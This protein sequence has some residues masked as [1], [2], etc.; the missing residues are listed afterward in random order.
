[1]L[2]RLRRWLRP[3]PP[4]TAD[5]PFTELDARRLGAIRRYFVRHPVAMDV[6]VALWYSFF[7]VGSSLLVIVGATDA[8]AG[9][10]PYVGGVQL[11]V[12]VLGGLVLMRRRHEPV[13]TVA[14]LVVLAIGCLVLVHEAGGLEFAL[15]LAM[16]A[17]A[18][19]RPPAVTWIVELIMVVVVGAANI[20]W[21][22]SVS[23]EPIR[24][25]EQVVTIVIA[26]IAVLI[27]FSVV[28]IAIGVGVRGRRQHI[29]SL[30]QRANSL[31][32]DREQQA[33]L[34]VADERTRIA[35][36]LHDVVAHSLTVMVALADGARAAVPK[37]PQDAQRALD[38]LT[39]TGRS[40]LSDM[41]RVLGVLR[42]PGDDAPLEP[43][44]D[45]GLDEL[46]ERFRTAG[47][48]VRLVRS[49]ALD[50]LPMAV[51]RST[52]RIVQESL[53]N[54]LRHAPGSPLVLVELE[55]LAD[56]AGERIEI[57]VTNES[58]PVVGGTA[59]VGTGRGILGMRERAASLGG[60]VEAGA[61]ER[62]WQV[63]AVL[64]IGPADAKGGAGA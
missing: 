36:E 22:R 7:A 14:A 56:G 61:H 31:A 18:V 24:P 39:E 4:P 10:Q 3:L 51:R 13:L 40:A 12:A 34:A 28:A 8:T 63:R 57:R 50:E 59:M 53:T 21:A 43:E 41:R 29:A 38:A 11:V 54:V 32:R 27:M 58:G 25:F 52:W 64:P 5:G 19:A 47:L 37:N 6:L 9:P 33:A 23:G 46:V 26:S 15:G 60:S 55:H 44:P 2:A 1:M 35:R 42:E 30:I 49:G 48:P 62:G 45:V 20:L 17:V 16:Y